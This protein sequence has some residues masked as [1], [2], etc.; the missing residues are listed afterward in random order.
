MNKFSIKNTI[1]TISMIGATFGAMCNS[2]A[3]FYAGADTGPVFNNAKLRS[4]HLSFTNPSGRFNTSSDYST[5]DLG[6]HAGYMHQINHE[7]M[8]EIEANITVKTN[9]EEKFKYQSLFN[10]SVFDGFVFK[11]HVQGSLKGRLGHNLRW[12]NESI[13]PYLTTG[14]SFADV[15]LKYKNEATDRYSN[16]RISAGWLIGTGAEW[17]FQKNWSLRIEY[18]YLYYGRAVKLNLPI[19]YGLFDPNSKATVDLD[20]NNVFV[21]INYWL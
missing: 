19:I 13:F 10:P 14:I 1:I 4:Q 2:W 15:E 5:F 6:V 20:S 3:R 8:S 11:N 17:W 9:Q 16:S 21:A 7:L 18:N 12:D